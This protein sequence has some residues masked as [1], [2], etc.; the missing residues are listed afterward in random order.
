MELVR[1]LRLCSEDKFQVPQEGDHHCVTGDS[2]ISKVSGM[3]Y[4]TFSVR[5]FYW[6]HG[7]MSCVWHWK[8]RVPHSWWVRGC[9]LFWA[10]E[11]VPDAMEMACTA[12]TVLHI[13]YGS[14]KGKVE[15]WNMVR[16]Q[17]GQSWILRIPWALSW[18]LTNPY[19]GGLQSMGLQK[20]QT[21]LS[22]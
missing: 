8:P 10:E 1:C 9:L 2:L 3:L 6:H 17:T 13:L 19:P 5:H 22:D 18:A 11:R 21:W 12:F 15:P 16:C 7:L 14:D 20:S 4:F